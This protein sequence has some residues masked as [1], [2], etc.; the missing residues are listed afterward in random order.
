[1]VTFKL[2]DP[3]FLSLRLGLNNRQESRLKMKSWSAENFKLNFEDKDR[4][5]AAP[6][7]VPGGINGPK[8]PRALIISN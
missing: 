6:Q 1:M 8:W 7:G 5:G 3:P 4:E 2:S